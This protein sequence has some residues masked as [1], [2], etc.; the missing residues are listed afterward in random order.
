M[1][2]HIRWCPQFL[3]VKNPYCRR[4]PRERAGRGDKANWT[5]GRGLRSRSRRICG[6]DGGVGVVPFPLRTPA[7]TRLHLRRHGRRL[8]RSRR[9][10]L[11]AGAWAEP[12]LRCQL[13]GDLHRPRAVGDRP[14]QHPPRPPVDPDQDLRG[15]DDCDGGAV[16]RLPARSRLSTASGTSTACMARAGRGGPLVAGAAFAT[17]LDALHRPDPDHDPRRRRPA[18]APG[19]RGLPARRLLGRPR[20]SPSCSPRSP[21]TR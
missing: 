6:A 7:R 12:A 21:S 3:S 14:R 15:D 13:L 18:R 8:R 10:E 16:R 4:A 9:G 1:A 2:A 17:R 11:E 5:D 20:R 19:P